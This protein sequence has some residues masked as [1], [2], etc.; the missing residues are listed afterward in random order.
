MSRN[1]LV[2]RT[3]DAAWRSAN[4][5]PETLQRDRYDEEC[6]AIGRNMRSAP[7]LKS[8]YRRIEGVSDL[9]T[10]WFAILLLSLMTFAAIL[11]I[12][13]WR[14]GTFDHLIA[15]RPALVIDRSWMR[16]IA[17]AT[18]AAASPSS[19]SEPADVAPPNEIEKLLD[20]SRPQP[21]VAPVETP[22]SEPGDADTAE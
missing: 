5:V 1:D 16:G 4:A 15:R 19:A 18:D 22:A 14:D 12:M 9:L 3:Q 10:H 20:Q 11:G 6:A 21:A 17:G 2:R 7:E 8:A 13:L